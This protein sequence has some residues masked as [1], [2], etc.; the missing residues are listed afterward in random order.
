M[1]TKLCWFVLV[2]E[3]VPASCHSL[4]LEDVTSPAFT[5]TPQLQLSYCVLEY[6]KGSINGI[7]ICCLSS[8]RKSK[9]TWNTWDVFKLVATQQ[10]LVLNRVHCYS[11]QSS[12]IT[13]RWQSLERCVQAFVVARQ[14]FC[15]HSSFITEVMDRGTCTMRQQTH[16]EASSSKVSPGMEY[17]QQT[18]FAQALMERSWM[19]EKEA[20]R[21]FQD[22][23]GSIDG[24]VN[25]SEHRK[26]TPRL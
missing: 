14:P 12:F 1:E 10:S 20:K 26:G 16:G 25:S 3:S 11:F 13:S 6:C 24:I 15:Q 19:K 2:G 17:L 5:A 8:K 18:T 23:T 7:S 9:S 4:S 22:I 21:L